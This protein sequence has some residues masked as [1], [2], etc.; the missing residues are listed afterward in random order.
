MDMS[1][2]DTL[3]ALGLDDEATLS[4]RT[5]RDGGGDFFTIPSG[6]SRSQREDST[7]TLGQTPRGVSYPHPHQDIRQL[8]TAGF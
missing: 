6:W 3:A 8:D 7:I 1:I 2:E 4:P 5:G